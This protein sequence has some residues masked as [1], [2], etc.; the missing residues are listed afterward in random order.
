VFFV[1]LQVKELHFSDLE[2]PTKNEKKY[3]VKKAEAKTGK[4]KFKR[5]EKTDIVKIKAKGKIIA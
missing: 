2:C 5:I 3:F 1:D 4:M